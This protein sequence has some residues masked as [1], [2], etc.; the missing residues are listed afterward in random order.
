MVALD[1]PFWFLKLHYTRKLKRWVRDRKDRIVSIWKD[2]LHAIRMARPDYRAMIARLELRQLSPKTL[3]PERSWGE[4]TD[5]N[6]IPPIKAK[7]KR[8]AR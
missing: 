1:A 3:P 6:G 2:M 7:R 5:P 8:G 4:I